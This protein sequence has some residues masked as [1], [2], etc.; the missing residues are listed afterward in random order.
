ME[1]GDLS[2]LWSNLLPDS[3]KVAVKLAE[4]PFVSRLSIRLLKSGDWSPH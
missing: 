4:S 1:C 2:P 3:G